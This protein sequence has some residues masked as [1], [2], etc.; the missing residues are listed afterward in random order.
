MDDYGAL[1]S[2]LRVV[3]F[4]EKQYFNQHITYPI[5]SKDK[6]GFERL[7]KLVQS[8]SLRRTKTTEQIGIHLP[9]R[10][11]I[12]EFVE[13]NEEE[14]H[15]HNIIKKS[16]AVLSDLCDAN[17]NGRMGN[18]L[19]T[20]TK[21]RQVC[22]HGRWLLS[23]ATL[24]A[25]KSYDLPEFSFDISHGL[26]VCVRC[27]RIPNASKM[28]ELINSHVSY[29][30]SMAENCLFTAKNAENMFSSSICDA[31]SK[32]DS[33]RTIDNLESNNPTTIQYE[34]YDP[35]SKVLALMKNLQNDCL[36]IC[37]PPIKRSDL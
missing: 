1:I 6:I 18:V 22:N 31:C 28:D 17:N 37:S 20:I 26:E 11:N 35:S 32:F 36:S 23:T 3:P 30:Q 8:T 27:A 24:A 12:V 19:S 33:Q 21:L 5:K 25:L 29:H 16:A 10:E 13:L 15:L 2:F 7:K 14:R 4:N 34:A 9:A